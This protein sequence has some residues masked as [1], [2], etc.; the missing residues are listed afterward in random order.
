MA[1]IGNIPTVLVA[2]GSK[3]EIEEKVREYC[4]NVGPGGAGCWALRRASWMAYR[5][6][7]L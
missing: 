2:Y 4:I 6:R 7:T 1:L 3:E 5:P